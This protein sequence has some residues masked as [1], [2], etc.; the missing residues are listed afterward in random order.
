MLL[1]LQMCEHIPAYYPALFL[2]LQSTV[3]TYQTLLQAPRLAKFD[4]NFLKVVVV[5]E[6]HHAAAP[7]YV[8]SW[9]FVHLTIICPSAVI[10]A[11]WDTLTLQWELK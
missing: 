1:E 2:M 7:S 4:P 9:T 6:A 3:A 11:Y 10:A 5:D 8:L